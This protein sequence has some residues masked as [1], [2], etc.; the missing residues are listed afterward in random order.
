M[1]PKDPLLEPFHYLCQLPGKEIRT[2]LIKA[3]DR[4]LQVPKEKLDLIIQIIGMLHHA[5]LL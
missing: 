4:W 2:L 5:S 1:S 3:F